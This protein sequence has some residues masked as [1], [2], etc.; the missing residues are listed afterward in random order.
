MSADGNLVSNPLRLEAF[1]A[2]D[3]G[4]ADSPMAWDEKSGR[5]FIARCD[6]WGQSDVEEQ[7]S[8]IVIQL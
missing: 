3:L 1:S 6:E 5:L 2:V 8:L 7:F 4:G